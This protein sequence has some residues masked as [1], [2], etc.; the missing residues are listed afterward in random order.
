MK[1]YTDAERLAAYEILLAE[2]RERLAPF[3]DVSDGDDGRQVPNKFMQM[4]QM[5]D[6]EMDK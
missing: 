5:I 3:V 2:L 1:R 6:E 4:V